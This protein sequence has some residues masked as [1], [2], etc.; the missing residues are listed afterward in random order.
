[1]QV[2]IIGPADGDFGAHYPPLIREKRRP[3]WIK[4]GLG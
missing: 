3:Q 4:I 1:M 2:P